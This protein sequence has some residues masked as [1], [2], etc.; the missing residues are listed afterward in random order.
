MYLK[1]ALRTETISKRKTHR[2]KIK[3][4]CREIAARI[5]DEEKI[6]IAEMCKRPEIKAVAFKKNGKPY[7]E[8]TIRKWIRDLS[9]DR[10]PGRRPKKT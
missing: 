10:S 1:R 4:E 6:T 9:P 3:E 2:D 8:M 7:K 5:W